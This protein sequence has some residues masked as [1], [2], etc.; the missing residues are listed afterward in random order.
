MAHRRSIWNQ[1]RRDLYLTQRAMGDIT[2][3][4]R[5]PQVLTKRLVRRSLRRNLFRLFR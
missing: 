4:Q 5:G 2:A 3:A 1:I